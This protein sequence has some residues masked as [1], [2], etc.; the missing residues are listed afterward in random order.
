MRNCPGGILK[1]K[2]NTE[3][4]WISTTGICIKRVSWRCWKVRGWQALGGQPW[5]SCSSGAGLQ[6]VGKAISYSQM[7]SGHHTSQAWIPQGHTNTQPLEA[8]GRVTYQ[9]QLRGAL[10]CPMT[11][12][13]SERMWDETRV[14]HYHVCTYV[15]V[16]VSVCG[17]SIRVSVC[18]CVCVCLCFACFCLCYGTFNPQLGGGNSHERR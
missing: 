1:E 18:V 9:P 14:Y 4:V 17:S 3:C 2:K 5:G 16:G 6:H 15:R 11:E 10:L 7:L 12:R 13:G 8:L